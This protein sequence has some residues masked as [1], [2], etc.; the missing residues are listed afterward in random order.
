MVEDEE[1]YNEPVHQCFLPSMYHILF[2]YRCSGVVK[3]KDD[4]LKKRLVFHR[5]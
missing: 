4:R 5:G 1:E 3:R 2:F